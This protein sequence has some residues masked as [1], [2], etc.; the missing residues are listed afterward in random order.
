MIQVK[1]SIELITS[2]KDGG[3]GIGSGQYATY[4]FET[5]E[6]AK[7]YV[8]GQLRRLMLNPT[9]F[10]ADVKI[11]DHCV[12][13]TKRLGKS[14]RWEYIEPAADAQDADGSEAACE[15]MDKT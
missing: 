9:G 6:D 14:Y 1:E 3:P 5:K 15:G 10:S 4:I 8:Y 7:K 13:A 11:T 12:E 2:G